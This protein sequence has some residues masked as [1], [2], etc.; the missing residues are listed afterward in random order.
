MLGVF[1]SEE[2]MLKYLLKQIMRNVIILVLSYFWP[3]TE[4][5]PEAG[6]KFNHDA[7]RTSCHSYTLPKEDPKFLRGGLGLSSII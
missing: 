5:I 4:E 2:N 7:S 1:D 3:K 6:S